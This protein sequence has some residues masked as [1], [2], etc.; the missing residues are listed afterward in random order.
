MEIVAKEN[1]V[2]VM[3]HEEGCLTEEVIEDPM[4]IPRRISETWQPQLIDDLPDAFCGENEWSFAC[5]V[6]INL[7][8]RWFAFLIINPY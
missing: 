4:L 2:M 1:K 5:L 6:V 3:D 7:Y 8:L